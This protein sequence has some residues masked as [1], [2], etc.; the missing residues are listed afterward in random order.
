[1]KTK[2]FGVA[3]IVAL[4]GAT[5][6]PSI[7]DGDKDTH[8]PHAEPP[9]AEVK[10]DYL[11]GE[12]LYST[13]YYSPGYWSAVGT[14]ELVAYHNALEEW[15]AG[16]VRAEQERLAA[17]EAARLAEEKAQRRAA[18][19]QRSSGG[20]SSS[21]VGDDVW[22]ALAQC[23]S[24]GNPGMNSGNGFYGAF[25]FLPS[26]WASVGGSGLPHE[27]SYEEQKYRAQVLQ[28]RSG[29]GQWPACSSKLGLR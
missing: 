19:A 5:L 28:Q 4:I 14:V 10:S 2:L 9:K 16:I 26:T 12:Y 29:W 3:A 13:K 23:E 1:M 18:Q 24:S 27:N 7:L 25:Q 6:L 21:V 15:Y 8:P 20:T 22:A 11:N 17:E